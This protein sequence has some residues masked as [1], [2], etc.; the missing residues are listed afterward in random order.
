MQGRVKEN[1]VA[2]VVKQLL[3]GLAHM[4]THRI[5]HRDLKPENVLVRV[6]TTAVKVQCSTREKGREVWEMREGTLL[7]DPH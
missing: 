5:A 3:A 6:T 2:V 7:T 4:A 1:V